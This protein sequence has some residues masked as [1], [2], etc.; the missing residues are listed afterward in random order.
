MRCRNA[1]Q[2]YQSQKNDEARFKLLKEYVPFAENDLKLYVPKGFNMSLG[3]TI[4]AKITLNKGH[5][6]IRY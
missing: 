1:P 2:L 4:D 5:E 6:T 3:E